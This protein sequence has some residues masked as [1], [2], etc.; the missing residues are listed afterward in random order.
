MT[1]KATYAPR[2]SNTAIKPKATVNQF[3]EDMAIKALIA[4]YAPV[5]AAKAAADAAQA[6]KA[7][8]HA[9]LIAEFKAQQATKA[10]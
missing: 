1:D 7:R 3:N 6:A 2:V 8:H 10:S 9:K 5:A 4:E